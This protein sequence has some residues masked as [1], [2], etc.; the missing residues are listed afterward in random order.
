MAQ[1]VPSL[2]LSSCSL[3]MR[4][5]FLPSYQDPML[6]RYILLLL[7]AD[8]Q[9]SYKPLLPYVAFEILLWGQVFNISAAESA[10]ASHKNSSH[11]LTVRQVKRITEFTPTSTGPEAHMNAIFVELKINNLYI[12]LLKTLT[13]AIPY[14][15]KVSNKGSVSE[16]NFCCKYRFCRYSFI[17]H[18]VPP[19][20]TRPPM[21]IH[22]L[23]PSLP[24]PELP[25]VS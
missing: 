6:H 14:S 25:R 23:T 20:G 12:S 4:S 18:V 9:A 8:H 1:F 17:S 15:N 19:S 16:K 10:T 21:L 22:P 24:S 2:Q 5:I 3:T 7:I 13:F 11:L